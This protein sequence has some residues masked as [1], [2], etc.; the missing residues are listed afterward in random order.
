MNS[1][2]ATEP[3]ALPLWFGGAMC[4]AYPDV[5]EALADSRELE[6]AYN[7]PPGVRAPLDL[8]Q[9]ISKSIDVGHLA[10][11]YRGAMATVNF[12]ES[13]E[14]PSQTYFLRLTPLGGA[15]WE[16]LARADWARFIE[17]RYGVESF[18]ALDPHGD[19]QSYV[20]V[21]GSDRERVESVARAMLPE[22][23]EIPSSGWM[24]HRPYQ[25]TNWKSLDCGWTLR[26]AFG[27]GNSVMDESLVRIPES[28]MVRWYLDEATSP[29]EE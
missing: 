29:T 18:D 21:T 14:A 12:E 9:A 26:V 22:G 16:R 13:L 10:I 19:L 24:E 5:R 3:F 7:L 11:Y 23:A 1:T 17:Y 15:Q 6:L 2:G 8:H 20:E 25:V 28:A 27:T 4:T